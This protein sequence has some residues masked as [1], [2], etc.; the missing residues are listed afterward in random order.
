M[1]QPIADDESGG[2]GIGIGH[3]A[4]FGHSPGRDL[5]DDDLFVTGEDAL[6]LELNPRLLDPL[7]ECCHATDGASGATHLNLGIRERDGTIGVTSVDCLVPR[8]HRLDALVHTVTLPDMDLRSRDPVDVPLGRSANRPFRIFPNNTTEGTIDA[9]ERIG[10]DRIHDTA[11]RHRVERDDI[12]VGVHEA[13]P[14]LVGDD[15]ND[16]ADEERASPPAPSAQCSTQ[17]PG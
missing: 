2:G 5:F 11:N 4:C 12:R 10:L 14:A 8:Q 15:L 6:W 17:P 3:L 9:F 1:N 13:H 16:V 7:S